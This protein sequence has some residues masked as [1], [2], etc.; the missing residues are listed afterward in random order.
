MLPDITNP[1]FAELADAAEEAACQR[2]QPGAVYHPQQPGKECQFIRWLD[3]CQ[4]DGLLFT[5]NRPDNGLLRKEVQ[6][7]ERIVLLDEDIPGSKVP[8]V[9]ADNIRAGG[10]PPKN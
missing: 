1:F 2:L 9:F 6:R 5:T 4:V 7:H 10:S 3:T 8:K